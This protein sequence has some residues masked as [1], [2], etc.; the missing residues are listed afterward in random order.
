MRGGRLDTDNEVAWR[1][2]AGAHSRGPMCRCVPGAASLVGTSAGGS[3]WMD[4]N[5]A[6]ALEQLHA[7]DTAIVAIQ[8]SYLPSFF[9]LVID[10]SQV[11]LL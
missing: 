6:R 9:S 7:G 3:G 10:G 5:A 4:P 2:T 11:A 8:Y 1:G